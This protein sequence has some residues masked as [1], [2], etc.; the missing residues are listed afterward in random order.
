LRVARSFPSLGLKLK[1]AGMNDTPEEFVKKTAFA[2]FYLTT[3]VIFLVGAIFLKLNLLLRVLYFVFPVLFIFLFIYFMQVPEYKIKL[4]EKNID[5]EIVY[6]CRFLIIELESGVPLYNALNNVSK[7]Y[8]TIG[9]AFRDIVEDIDLGST[10]EDA[11]EDA[12]TLTPSQDFR[13]VL[14]QVLNSLKTGAEVSSSLNAVVDQITREQIIKV[15]EYGRK[16]NPIA[17]FYMM[18]AVILPSLGITMLII[19][20]SFLAF[21]LSLLVLIVVAF[22]LGCVQFMFIAMIKTSRPAVEM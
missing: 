17:M 3:T 15:S 14:W 16:L 10:V 20:S 13:K 8:K 21:E 5:R 22:A 19:L 2:S 4:K 7:S 9:R 12:I 1:Q 18:I 6:A 11:I